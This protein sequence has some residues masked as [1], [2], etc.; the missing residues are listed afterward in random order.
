MQPYGFQY[1]EYCQ[2]IILGKDRGLMKKI[3]V[4]VDNA[5]LYKGLKHIIEKQSLE[6]KYEF[7]YFFS[8]GHKPLENQLCQYSDLTAINLE[9]MSLQ[10]SEQFDLLLSLH[11][12]QKFPANLVNTCRCINIH[13]GYNPYNRGWYPQVFSIINKKPIGVTIHEM[14]VQ[15][16]HGPI[17]Y[18]ELIEIEDSDTSYS[19]YR[20]I[21]KKE[22]EL[23]DK[24]LLTLI[25]GNYKTQIIDVEGNINYKK[26]FDKLCKIDLGKNATYREVIDFLRA[27]TFNEYNNAYFIDENGDKIYVKIELTK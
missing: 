7:H 11:C 17:I 20:K 2:Q 27:M 23:L 16:D 21:Q 3:G 13:P 26:D 15:F 24:H 1:I 18:R 9:R 22:C 12:K 14:D 5:F 4:V 25:E 6:K 10:L 8:E 19:V